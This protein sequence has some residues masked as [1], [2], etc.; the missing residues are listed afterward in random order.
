MLEKLVQ[1]KKSNF[2]ID[3]NDNKNYTC[4]VLKEKNKE[5]VPNPYTQEKK[6]YYFIWRS[7]LISQKNGKKPT[8]ISAIKFKIL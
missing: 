5:P 6:K 3:L 4:W 1:S 8:I 7:W 2:T